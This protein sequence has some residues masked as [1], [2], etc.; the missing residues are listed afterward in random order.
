MDA[1]IANQIVFSQREEM[2]RG[3]VAWVAVDGLDGVAPASM[4]RAYSTLRD[5]QAQAV[6]DVKLFLG[7]HK[8]T[9]MQIDHM[10]GPYGR[11]CGE[12]A[13]QGISGFPF[14]ALAFH[15]KTHGMQK[16]LLADEIKRGRLWG[17]F[18]YESQVRGA[19]RAA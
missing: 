1:T 7:E 14:V 4:K 18:N 9:A 15:W 10:H 3:H 16:N 11:L 19:L 5:A 8:F 2:A 13:A 6:A 12:L 17:V